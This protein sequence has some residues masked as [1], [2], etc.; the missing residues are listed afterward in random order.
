MNIPSSQ[1]LNS[2]TFT[3]GNKVLTHTK[4]FLMVHVPGEKPV[5]TTTPAWSS[6]KTTIGTVFRMD[7]DH[8]TATATMGHTDH[9]RTNISQRSFYHGHNPAPPGLDES[10]KEVLNWSRVWVMN[11]INLSW[12]TLWNALDPDIWASNHSRLRQLFAL[13]PK[14]KTSY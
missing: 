4:I 1:L 13:N 10:H 8:E 7:L 3:T 14:A 6:N 11:C 12:L 2:G 9:A 5:S